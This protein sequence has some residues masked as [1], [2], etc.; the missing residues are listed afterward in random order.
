MLVPD[1]GEMSASRSVLFIPVEITYICSNRHGGYVVSEAIWIL[2][3][4]KSRIPARNH[5]PVSRS[6]SAQAIHCMECVISPSPIK[7]SPEEV[8]VYEITERE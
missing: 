2:Y 7:L 5:N 1:D 8:R 4:D 3:N 6:P